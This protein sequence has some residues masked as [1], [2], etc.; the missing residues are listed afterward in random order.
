MI[1]AL[2]L[3]RGRVTHF[4]S[5]PDV[6]PTFRA[7]VEHE[8]GEI[9]TMRDPEDVIRAAVASSAIPGVF[10]PERIDG[11]EFVDAGGFSNQ[12]L[13][14]AIANDADAVMVV[15]LSPSHSPAPTPPSTDLF[16]LAG[17][18]LEVANWRDLQTELR[19]LPEGWTRDGA[20]SRVCV[21]EPERPLPGTVLS[22]DPGQAADAHRSRRAGRVAGARARG[23]ARARA[24]RGPLSRVARPQL[25]APG[26][27]GYGRRMAAPGSW[28]LRCDGGSR[29]NPGPAAFGF[30]LTDPAGR[31][32]EA[33]G[34]YIGSA[35]NNVAEYG[36]LIAGLEAAAARGASPLSV[37]MD[38]E[39]VIRQMTGQYRVKHEG[40]KPLHRKRAHGGGGAL[41]GDVRYREA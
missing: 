2:A 37:V 40:L 10:E 16:S 25:A 41:E 22:F 20:P 17:R 32:V 36:G 31:E 26:P 15:L 14:V 30:V 4:V 5:W 34:E 13:H 6:S 7:R 39:L 11:R 3:D 19:T 27:T 23:V 8:L 9:V 33:R 21:I 28:T 35:T 24:G 18:L 1:G 12:P 38:S 29:G